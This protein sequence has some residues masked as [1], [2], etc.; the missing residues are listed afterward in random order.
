[1]ELNDN[2]VNVNKTSKI[3]RKDGFLKVQIKEN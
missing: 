1:M 2:F 3:A